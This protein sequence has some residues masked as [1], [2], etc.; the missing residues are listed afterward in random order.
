MKAACERGAH[1]GVAVNRVVGTG[2]TVAAEG[3]QIEER[4]LNSG[5]EDLLALGG[6]FEWGEW[7]GGLGPPPHSR[8]YSTT[9]C[10]V[11]IRTPKGFH[12]ELGF[13]RKEEKKVP[14]PCQ[15]CQCVS[16]SF[17]VSHCPRLPAISL[18]LLL[19]GPAQQPGFLPLFSA[20]PSGGSP[21]LLL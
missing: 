6:A 10:A 14:H 11:T 5:L 15:Q 4:T 3:E 7:G 21:S 16:L 1:S 2:Q 13:A 19:Q 17:S 12:E 8:G 18:R 20:S 9:G